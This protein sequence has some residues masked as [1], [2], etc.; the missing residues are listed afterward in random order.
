MHVTRIYAGSDGKSHFE[1][2]ALDFKPR[3]DGQSE[4]TPASN[5]KEAFF[6]RQAVGYQ[7][8]WHTAPGRQYVITLSG[9]GEIEVGD[10]SKKLFEP[11]DVL[12]AE[13]T[14]GQGHVTRVVGDQPRTMMWVPLD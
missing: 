5:A 10:G 9:Q 1:E 2:V 6:T 12:L 4:G 3:A 11:G 13:D 7:L 8:D 14:T